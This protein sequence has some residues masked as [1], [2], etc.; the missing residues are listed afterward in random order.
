MTFFSCDSG[1]SWKF[2]SVVSD[3]YPPSETPLKGEGLPDVTESIQ[4]T[5]TLL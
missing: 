3:I 2:R 5:A 4:E 1:P